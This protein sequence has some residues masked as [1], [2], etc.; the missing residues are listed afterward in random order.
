MIIEMGTGERPRCTI[1]HEI[2][3]VYEPVLVVGQEPSR[4]TSLASD[5]Q[6]SNNGC[7]LMHLACAGRS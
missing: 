4:P 7:Q 6:L 5:P 2:V 1:C 3:G